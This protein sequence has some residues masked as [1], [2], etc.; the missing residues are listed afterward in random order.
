MDHHSDV[1]NNEEVHKL[2]INEEV[3]KF[4]PSTHYFIMVSSSNC[5]NTTLLIKS[6]K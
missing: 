4:M 5:K 6:G 3:S 1:L 2:P